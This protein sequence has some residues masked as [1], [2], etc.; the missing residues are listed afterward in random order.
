MI[1]AELHRVL[2]IRLN[3][4][5]HAMTTEQFRSGCEL[6]LFECV[7]PGLERGGNISDTFPETFDGN[8]SFLNIG[9]C[10]KSKIG[11]NQN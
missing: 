9:N 7:G 3:K 5:N 1:S 8:F 6:Q 11:L 10:K 2:T 4:A